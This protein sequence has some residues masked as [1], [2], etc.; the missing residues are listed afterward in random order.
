MNNVTVIIQARINSTRLPGKVLLPVNNAPVLWYLLARLTSGLPLGYTTIVAIPDGEYIKFISTMGRGWFITG[1]ETDVLQRFANVAT[2]KPSSVYV[3]VTADCPLIDPQTIIASVAYLRSGGYDHV[4]P[5]GLPDGMGCD[6]F[7]HETLMTMLR[8]NPT[9][10]EREHVT[11]YALRRPL[12]FNL[13]KLWYLPDNA[14]RRWT[15]DTADDFALIA[16]VLRNVWPTNPM[17]TYPDLLRYMNANPDVEKLNSTVNGN[18]A[19]AD[20]G[21][22][23][24]PPETR[25]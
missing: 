6:V 5:E 10:E 22:P 13:G 12:Q 17:F 20:R 16:N 19:L 25:T 7:T 18:P 21:K 14:H 9:D 3:R 8:E 1:P 23:P 15:L 24:E 4:A 11:L 2:R